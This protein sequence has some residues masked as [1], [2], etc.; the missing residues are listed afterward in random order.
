MQ[1][2]SF[3]IRNCIIAFTP[4][5]IFFMVREAAKL[6]AH[7]IVMSWAGAGAVVFGFDFGTLVTFEDVTAYLQGNSVYVTG[8]CNVICILVFALMIRGKR[9]Q[10]EKREQ[11]RDP[12]FI[13]KAVFG[14]LC[15]SLA[16]SNIIHLLGID[17]ASAGY[18]RVQS[19]F[20]GKEMAVLIIF[21]GIIAPVSEELCFRGLM[22][23]ALKEIA[24]MAPAMVISAVCFGLIHG[25][26]AQMLYAGSLGLLLAFFY[27]KGGS[28]IAPLSGHIAVN[29]LAV[30]MSTQ[31][32]L[33]VMYKNNMVMIG[34]TMVFISSTVMIVNGIKGSEK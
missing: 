15:M 7:N 34:F 25:N 26:A 4:V 29:I 5:L 22:Y 1:K 12:A 24:G 11:G 2:S 27:E 16:V 14:S 8:I 10:E 33:G 3:D 20:S 32:T 18:Q 19:T 30:F 31:G 13:V 21:L 17:A 6:V 9:A 23:P 28:I